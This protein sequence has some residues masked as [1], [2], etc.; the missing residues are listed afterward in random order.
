[1]RGLLQAL[2]RLQAPDREQQQAAFQVLEGVAQLSLESKAMLALRAGEGPDL[3]FTATTRAA[4][5]R[6]ETKSARK[7]WPSRAWDRVW[8]IKKIL[9]RLWGMIGHLVKVREWCRGRPALA[10]GAWLRRASPSRS[11]RRREP[12]RASLSAPHL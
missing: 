5:L 10:F 4:A 7:R 11:A 12:L 9:P 8:E 2:D 1:M 3:A 6:T